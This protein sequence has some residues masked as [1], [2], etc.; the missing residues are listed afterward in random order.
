MDYAATAIAERRRNPGEDLLSQFCVAEIDGERL[1][2]REVL[3]T[4]TTLIMAGVESLG[5]FTVMFA[6]NMAD[7]ADSRREIVAD[8][9]L[10]PDAAGP[11]DS[12][13]RLVRRFP[14]RAGDQ[15]SMLT[16]S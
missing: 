10:L 7:F 13:R 6:L 11:G 2:E 16:G 1:T 8:P 12:L 4:T 9:A 14:A 5:G 3:L 15:S